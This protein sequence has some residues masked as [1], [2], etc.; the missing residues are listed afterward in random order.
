[1]AE[2]AAWKFV[3]DHPGCFSLTAICPGLIFGPPLFKSRDFTSG[4]I[5]LRVLND[6]VFMNVPMQIPFVD[7]R[8]VALAHVRALERPEAANQRYILVEGTYWLKSVS[9]CLEVECPYLG[10]KPP[11]LTVPQCVVPVLCKFYEELCLVLPKM[12]QEIHVDHTKSVVELGIRYIH[13]S[14]SVRDMAEAFLY[15][16]FVNKGKF[17]RFS[18]MLLRPRL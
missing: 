15:M 5:F 2:K 11:K 13:L 9:E 14:P 7:V 1:M 10:I 17:K 18:R 4:K 12:G 6:E 8:D 16:G 3:K